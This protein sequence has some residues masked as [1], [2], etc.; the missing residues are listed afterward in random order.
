MLSAFQSFIRSQ[1][2]FKK[3]DRILLA[4]SGGLDSVVMTHL[5]QKAGYKFSIAHCNFCM[6]GK[7]SDAEEIFVKKMAKRMNVDFFSTRFATIDYAEKHKKSIQEAA[8][9]LRYTWFENL[10]IKHGFADVATAHHL[11]DSIETFFI[12]L[13]RS[14]GMDGL[15]GIAAKQGFVRRPLL[16]ATRE[17]IRQYATKEKIRYREDSSNAGDD[18]LRNKI[19]HKLLPVLEELNSG[20]REHIAQSMQHIKE[21]GTVLNGFMDGEKKRLLHA[22]GNNFYLLMSELRRVSPL[23]FYLHDLL[24]SFG[25]HP[26]VLK[27]LEQLL[28]KEHSS[29]KKIISANYELNLERDR[30]LVSPRKQNGEKQSISVSIRKK[31]YAAPFPFTLNLISG[32]MPGKIP[33]HA[34]I[35]CLDHGKLVF[36]LVLRPWKKGDRFQPLGMKGRKLLSDYFTDQ[37]VSVAKKEEAWVLE[38]EGQIVWLVGY[39]IDE[40]YKVDQKTRQILQITLG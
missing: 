18:Y 28:T 23:G 12:N 16:F 21:A 13:L 20:Y 27:Q 30:C 38:S 6:R 3:E 19:R 24:D 7:E 17:A 5:F 8:R 39:R 37:K 22:E 4:V 32:S 15:K 10:R 35:A 31:V 26:P 2:L 1:E 11:D 36:P 25:F 33:S 40:R 9:D 34:S 29:G 14:S